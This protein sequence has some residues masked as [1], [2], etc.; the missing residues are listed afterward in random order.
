MPFVVY[1]YLLMKFLVFVFFRLLHILSL[2]MIRVQSGQFSISVLD[3]PD[4][5]EIYMD[6]M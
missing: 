1:F 2:S 6:V 5:R 4:S 3:N